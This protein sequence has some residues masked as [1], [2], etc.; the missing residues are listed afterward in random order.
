MSNIYD[1]LV[2]VSLQVFCFWK[3]Q[4]SSPATT[5]PPASYTFVVRRLLIFTKHKDSEGQ[6]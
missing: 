1:E 3:G 5:Y 6:K 4:G 2:L